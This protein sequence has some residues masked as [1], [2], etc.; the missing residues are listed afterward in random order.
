MLLWMYLCT[1]FFFLFLAK[2]DLPAGLEIPTLLP[3]SIISVPQR[4]LI[5]NFAAAGYRKEK[6]LISRIYFLTLNNR[7]ATRKLELPAAASVQKSYSQSMEKHSNSAQKFQFPVLLV[8]WMTMLGNSSPCHS[9]IFL[10]IFHTIK[11][12]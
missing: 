9:S 12:I 2:A 11:K 8:Y 7:L 4:Y 6:K 1:R 5:W 3:S 10:C